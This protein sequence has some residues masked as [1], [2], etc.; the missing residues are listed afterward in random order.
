VY[1]PKEGIVQRTLSS[2]VGVRPTTKGANAARF[3]RV[4]ST[5]HHLRPP[6]S[7]TK[8]MWHWACNRYSR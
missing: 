7:K 3:A 2:G 5:H 4:P 6:R 1:R 8:Y